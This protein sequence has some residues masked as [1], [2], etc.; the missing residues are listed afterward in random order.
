MFQ[1]IVPSVPLPEAERQSY[2]RITMERFGNPFIRHELISIAL[3]SVAKWKVR[4]LPTVKDHVAKYGVVPAG[5]AFSLAALL[6][7]YRGRME[8]GLYVGRREAGAFPI[9][10]DAA[11]IGKL[12]AA[13]QDD[14]A[15]QV[16]GRVLVDVA[17][18]GEDLSQIPGLAGQ[19]TADLRRIAEGGMRAALQRLVVT[20]GDLA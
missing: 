12:A 3:N 1:E 4:V 2:A 15:A 9:R 13:W 16:A 11:T 20:P 8:N 18:W 19:V 17:L 6:W 7:F 10:D 14:D 5:L